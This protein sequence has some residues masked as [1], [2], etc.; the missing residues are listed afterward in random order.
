MK[1]NP[2][3]FYSYIN[4]RCK[5]QSKVG[6][7]KDENGQVQTDDLIQAKILNKQFTSA[8]TREDLSTTPVP[9][10][11]FDPGIGP[12]LTTT[13]ITPDMVAG[14]IKLLKPGSCG[15]DKI[16]PHLLREL[17]AQL[18][19]PISIVFNKLALP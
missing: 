14:K 16:G 1:K 18:V 11:I 6:P 9:I 5:V 13:E 12:P 8:F 7:L 15:P 2:K 4:N 3:V 17:S 10:Q 19:L